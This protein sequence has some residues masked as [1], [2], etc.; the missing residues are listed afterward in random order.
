MQN[1]NKPFING[2]L[3]FCIFRKSL[4][5][6]LD[7]SLERNNLHFVDMKNYYLKRLKY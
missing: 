6:R 4:K 5:L 2:Y 7:K 1:W 3:K